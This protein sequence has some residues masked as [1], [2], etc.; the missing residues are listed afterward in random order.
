MQ[1]KIFILK[2]LKECYF[3][4]IYNDNT[5]QKQ[6]HKTKQ[7]NKKIREIQNHTCKGNFLPRMAAV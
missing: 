1:T 7:I 2:K 5:I 3:F 6:Q 4:L